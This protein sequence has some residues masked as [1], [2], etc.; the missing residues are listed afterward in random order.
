MKVLE[1][2]VYQIKMAI[3]SLPDHQV[4]EQI[5]EKL[6]LLINAVSENDGL[7]VRSITWYLLGSDASLETWNI[8]NH[9]LALQIHS[10]I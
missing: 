9:D 6:V 3:L 8:L 2:Y 10:A 5:P 7:K 4:P 1:R